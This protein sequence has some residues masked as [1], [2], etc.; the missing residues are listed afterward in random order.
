MR[1]DILFKGMCFMIGF[2]NNAIK[3]V[4]NNKLEYVLDN[5]HFRRNRQW[6]FPTFINFMLFRKRTTLRHSIHSMYKLL[7][8]FHFEKVS[9]SD[10]SQQR[11]YIDPNAFKVISKEF[12]KNIGI[13]DK[14]KTLKTFKGKRVFAGDGSDLEILNLISTRFAFN[15]K[16]KKSNYTYPAIAKF[17]AVMDVL[18]G[19]LL[20]GILGDFKEGDL[21][22]SHENLKNIVGLVDFANSIF[23]YDRGYVGL[24]LY[25]R[26]LELGTNFVIRLKEGVYKEEINN[27]KSDD[28]IVRL[29]LTDERLD[30]F[31]DP[32]LKAKYEKQ[33]YIE[34]RVVKTK[35]K[36]IRID[37]ETGR[38]YEDEVD[39]ILLTNMSKEEMSV[40]DLKYIYKLRWGIEVNFN[41]LKHRFNIENFTGTIKITHQQDLYSQFL[42]Y[43]IFCYVNNLLNLKLEKRF[44]DKCGEEYLDYDFEYKIN[45]ANLIRNLLED[46]AAIML[47][48]LREHVSFL[49][50]NLFTEALEDPIKTKK[51]RHEKHDS[52]KNWQ[53][54]RQNCKP[55]S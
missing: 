14:K 4:T 15:V 7:C 36:V 3:H 31:H 2:V 44:V 5:I 19:Y 41:T 42:T 22:L 50:N 17:S 30:K 34:L 27:M 45:Q 46:I 8:K 18:N 11:R 40:E 48:P 54:F 47:M 26:L 33:E 52:K 49:L 12:L 38:E 13:T 6:P 21:P 37:E 43:N 25:A 23:T 55:M 1:V 24:E 32:E 28:E 20:D 10:F 35:V 16:L 29:K 9:S 51:I 39:E 53:K